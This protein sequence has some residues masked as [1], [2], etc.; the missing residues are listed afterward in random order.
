MLPCCRLP[1]GGALGVVGALTGKLGDAAAFVSMDKREREH[2]RVEQ[3]QG[4]L[5]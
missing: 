3:R 5:G 1:V 4:H 2:R